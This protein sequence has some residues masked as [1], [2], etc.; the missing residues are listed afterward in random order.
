MIRPYSIPRS[1]A[2]ARP[3]T[4]RIALNRPS[5]AA[6]FRALLEWCI[7]AN[8]LDGGEFRLFDELQFAIGIPV[9]NNGFT[10]Q[11]ISRQQTQCEGILNEALDRTAHR[12]RSIRFVVTLV[13]DGFFGF[14]R[15]LEL[16]A[17]FAQHLTHAAQL[18]I[19]DHGE[20]LLR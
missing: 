8:C 7:M 11:E 2:M 14:R 3:P 15:Y 1:P 9:R 5:R 18:K 4:I 12:P 16:D 17:A 20:V 6:V 19:D 10:S 13:H